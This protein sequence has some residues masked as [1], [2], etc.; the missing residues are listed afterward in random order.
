[1]KSG[2][3]WLFRQLEQH[4]GIHFS[5]EKELHYLA[6]SSGHRG[7]LTFGY[8]LGRWRNARA[9]SA[10]GLSWRDTAWYL[11]YLLAPRTWGWY[12]RRFSGVANGQYCA[13]FSNLSVLLSRG[14][15]ERLLQRVGELRIVYVLRDPLDR[16]WSHLKFHYHL[17]G[18]EAQLEMLARATSGTAPQEFLEHSLY[19]KHLRNMLEVLPREQIHIVYYDDISQRPEQVLRGVEA[20]LGLPAHDYAPAKLQ[21]RINPS[22]QL[23]RPRWVSERFSARIVQDLLDL[24]GLDIPVPQS[25]CAQ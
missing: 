1:M 7:A 16:I 2:T 4:P 11:D 19:A 23:P 21:R 9:R 3:T 24:E 25:W 6:D 12:E 20:F 15:W 18:D 10:D 14:D 5:P 8:R 17:G 22:A 13:D